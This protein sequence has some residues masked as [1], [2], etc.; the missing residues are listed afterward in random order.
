MVHEKG[1]EPS[2]P[3]AR[4][5]KSL[6]YASSITHAE[7]ILSN[8]IDILVARTGI[9]P[10]LPPWKGRDLAN[11]RTRHIGGPGE[12]RTLI[13]LINSQMLNQFSYWSKLHKYYIIIFII[14]QINGAHGRN[15]T[16]DTLIKSQMHYHYATCAYGGQGVIRTH[17]VHR[18][19]VY[20]PPQLSNSVAC[21]YN[22]LKSIPQLTIKY[23]ETSNSAPA[24][25]LLG[26][27]YLWLLIK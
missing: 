12:A 16:F 24:W 6:M 8:Y 11:S 5:F 23:R 10:V 25:I 20:S 17:S 26:E 13:L 4:D 7:V 18:Q 19:R 15:R 2:I 21:P 27:E 14:F 3:K 1:V 9:E 22:P